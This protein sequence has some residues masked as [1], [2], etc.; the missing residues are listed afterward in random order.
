MD[1]NIVYLASLL[2]G[3]I[4]G[5]ITPPNG[6]SSYQNLISALIKVSDSFKELST[7]LSSLMPN[8]G[9]PTLIQN[10]PENKLLYSDSIKH[11]SSFKQSAP[12]KQHE[13]DK[14]STQ[15]INDKTKFMEELVRLKNMR[16]D[17]YYKM[18]RN[19]IVSQLYEDNIKKDSM[20]I[21]KKFAPNFL[22]YDSHEIKV[23]KCNV[24]IQTTQSEIKTMRIHQKIQHSKQENFHAQII[25][26]INTETNIQERNKLLT[27]YDTIIKR[28]MSKVEN[29][30]H[31]K[32]TFLD[33]NAH[34]YTIKTNFLQK[35]QFPFPQQDM[36][37]DN[38]ASSS[39]ST[40]KTSNNMVQSNETS[41]HSNIRQTQVQSTQ[42][43]DNS[44]G[45]PNSSC[46]TQL[47]QNTQN[48]NTNGTQLHQSSK[49]TALRNLLKTASQSQLTKRVVHKND[50]T[51]LYR[52]TQEKHSS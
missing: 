43:T 4:K 49:P 27:N 9:Q 14:N 32:L 10:S 37:V 12:F 26:H 23:H 6:N 42:P 48:S 31:K 16:K 29:N 19:K 34:M 15:K 8:P 36:E 50:F 1:P 2:D 33:S 11:C 7:V 41:Q 40:K 38:N 39:T 46:K 5:L 18:F 21:P 47:V 24:A 20:R 28:A 44:I 51:T 25:Q 3:A 45:M 13:L 17:A 30:L 52:R 35:P 22:N